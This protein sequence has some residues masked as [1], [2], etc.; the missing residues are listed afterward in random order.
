MITV[1]RLSVCIARNEHLGAT[2]NEYIRVSSIRREDNYSSCTGF[3]DPMIT[4]TA[5]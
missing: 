2:T 4:I 3:D 1:R 5:T